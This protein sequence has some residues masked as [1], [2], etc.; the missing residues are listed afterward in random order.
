MHSTVFENNNGCVDLTPMMHPQLHHIAIKYHHFHEHV[1]KG[2]VRIL[3]ISTENQLAD[4]FSK[5]L[6]ASKLISPIPETTWMV[7]TLIHFT[8]RECCRKST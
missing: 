7:T 2:H 1:H 8:E 3:W 5:P 6:V 4:I